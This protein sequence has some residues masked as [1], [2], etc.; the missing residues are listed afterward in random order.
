MFRFGSTVIAA[1]LASSTVFAEDDSMVRIKMNKVPEEDFVESFFERQK[2]ETAIRLSQTKRSLRGKEE[3]EIVKDYQNAQYFA[4]VNVGTPSQKFNVIMDTGSSNLWVPVKGGSC[5]KIPIP[6][7]NKLPFF[8]KKNMFDTSASSTF[9]KL[10]EIFKIQYGSG[11]VSGLF[12]KDTVSLGQDLAVTGQD[13]ATIDNCGGMG[14]GYLVGKFDGILGLGFP[15]IS[16]GT[17][18][19]VFGNAIEQGLVLEPIFSFYLGNHKQGELTFGGYDKDHYTG[20]LHW[21]PLSKATYWQINP[22]EIK[23]GSYSMKDTQAIVDSGTSLMVGPTA[24]V[25]KIAKDIGASSIPLSPAY[26]I[27]C[28]KDIPDFE[29]TIDGKKYTIDGNDL[30][31]K[32]MGDHCMLAMQG[33]DFRAD[34]PQWIL[35]DVFMRKYYTVFDMKNEQIG[36]ALAK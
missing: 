4:E 19:T 32:S 15:S 17:K 34:G 28:E 20:D 14:I 6:F 24:E 13:F 33:M 7:I 30:K 23:M 31:M 16:V 8:S 1:L 5:G 2:V 29:V 21:V 36:F 12:A 35:G 11:A 18:P 27:D 25:K 10:T 26:F 9:K 3:N 22:S